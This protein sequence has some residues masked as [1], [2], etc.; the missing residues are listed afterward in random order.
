MLILLILISDARENVK[1]SRI[2]DLY[3]IKLKKMKTSHSLWKYWNKN[4]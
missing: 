1:H 4:V 2:L 3:E